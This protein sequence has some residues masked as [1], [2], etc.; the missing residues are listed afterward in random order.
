MMQAPTP[1]CLYGRYL[2]NNQRE[3]SID[4]QVRAIE[5]YAA[6]NGYVIVERYIDEALTGTTDDRQSFQ[7]MMADSK[8]HQWQY[9]IVHKLD[10]FAR[11]K[12][13]SVFHKRELKL[14]GVR[15]LSVTE[16]LDDSP[17]SAML[18]AVLEGMAEYYS[19]NLSREVKK[20]LRENAH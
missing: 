1:V 13:D 7:R 9:V 17:E 12:Y 11:N 6:R 2:S 16:N 18:E 8:A 5:E 20:G 15:V 14:N 10:R 19:R 4:A 3:E